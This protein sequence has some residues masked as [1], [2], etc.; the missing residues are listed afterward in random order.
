MSITKVTSEDQYKQLI[1]ASKVS[2]VLFSAEWAEQCK[3]ISD[4][5]TELAKQA[6]FKSLQ[7]LDVPAEDLSELSMRHQI[8]S[9]PTV[10]FLRAGTC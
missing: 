6:E 7:F 4:V 8:D 2:V 10:L 5:M 1:G 3:Q 9:V